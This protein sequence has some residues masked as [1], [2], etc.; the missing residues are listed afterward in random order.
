MLHLL[1]MRFGEHWA[2]LHELLGRRK[3]ASGG[4][5]RRKSAHDAAEFGFDTDHLDLGFRPFES[6]LNDALSS[7]YRS[8]S[9]PS[10]DSLIFLSDAEYES[11]RQF[12]AAIHPQRMETGGPGDGGDTA[13]LE[14]LLGT[15]KETTAALEQY[16][17]L[18]ATARLYVEKIVKNHE[19]RGHA[20]VD[21]KGCLSQG[22]QDSSEDP[23]EIGGD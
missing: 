8:A 2:V 15:L 5:R 23:G 3:P 19:E 13:P 14:Y 17:E 10:R 20:Y 16:Y 9:V 22:D 18:A 1:A 7:V 21:G 12:H 4:G 6:A 11:V